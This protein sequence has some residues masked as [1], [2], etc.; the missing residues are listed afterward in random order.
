MELE[1]GGG[2]GGGPQKKQ[3]KKKLKTP[4]LLK[5]PK[6]QSDNLKKLRAQI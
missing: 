3:K 1:V 5:T 6:K 2:G 4:I